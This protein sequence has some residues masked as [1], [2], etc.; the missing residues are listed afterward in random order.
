MAKKKKKKTRIIF[1]IPMIIS[2]CM[3]LYPW[4]SNWVNQRA[5][6]SDVI[7]YDDNVKSKS[8]EEID[9][10]IKKARE[11]N[12][13]LAKTKVVLTDPFVET[14][15][16]KKEG[17]VYNS[18]LDFGGNGMM[19][20]LEIPC[21][22]VNL[23]VFHG[24]SAEVLETG[25]GHLEGSSLPVGGETTHAVLTG[26]TGLNRAKLFTDLTELKEGDLFFIHVGG[27]NLAYEVSEINIVVPEDVSKLSIREGEDLVTLITC[28]PYGVNTHRLLVT[29]KRTT[30]TEEAYKEAGEDRKDTDSL[31]MRTY[32]R[33]IIGGVLI[34][35][36]VLITI[37]FI[38]KQFKKKKMKKE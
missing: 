3:L 16:Q 29:G 37:H 38:R 8:E 30:Y 10:M 27:E 28:T 18:L 21:I 14:E 4:I 5:A 34:A 31:W 35:L 12:K 33:A 7:A 32:K 15:E 11:Y 20:Y 22:A 19:A 9:E 6:D 17:L 26:H 2:L 36:V 24:T 13:E 1:I 25:I 23:P